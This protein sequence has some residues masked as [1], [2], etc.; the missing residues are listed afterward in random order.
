MKHSFALLILLTALSLSLHA[1]EEPA[2]SIRRVSRKAA[3]NSAEQTLDEVVVTGTQTY[4]WKA[5]AP[6]LTRVISASDIEKTDATDVEELLSQEIPGAEFSYAMNQLKH[7]N[8]NGFGGQ[9]ILF[10]V[11]GERLSG[12]TMDDVDFARLTM[13]NVQRVE[14]VKESGS[15]LYGSNAAGGII[16]IITKEQTEPLR[17]DVDGRVAKHGESRFRGAVGTSNGSVSNTLNVERTARETYS[18]HNGESPAAQVYTTVFGNQKWNLNDK[19]SFTP[20]EKFKITGHAGYYFQEVYRTIDTPERYRDFAASLRATWDITEKDNLVAS[21]IFDQY[22]KS[23]FQRLTGYDIRDYSN[24]KNSFRT[25][26]NHFRD[27]GDIFTAGAEYAYDYLLNT[28]LEGPSKN[29]YSCSSFAQYDWILSFKWEMLSA[30]RFDYFS[31]GK[32]SQITP[33]ISLRYQPQPELNLRMG[34]G[35]GFRAPALKEKYY[36]F[37]MEGIW[38]IKGNPQLKAEL[39]HNFNVSADYKKG[40]YGITA[41]AYY[42]KVQNKISTS[43]PHMLPNEGNQLFLEYI[44]LDSYSVYGSEIMLQGHWENGFGTSLSYAYTH[45]QLPSDKEGNSIS[46][47]YIPAR[48]H[49]LMMRF[50]WEKQ[51]SEK[52]KLRVTLNGRMLSSVKSAEY[53]DY[54]DIS[55]GMRQVEYPAYMLWKLS[56]CESFDDKFKLTLAVDNLLN[57]KPEYH[58]MNTPVT[59]GANVMIGCAFCF[60]KQR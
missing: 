27:D 4:K 14:I 1:E 26:Y 31:E 40:N 52:R 32:N 55:K 19:I 20:N 16:N 10:L 53:I 37:D 44:N 50:D 8:L 48:K 35:R 43:I 28:H 51:T 47:P 60:N 30:L 41:S 23:D 57:Y 7:L 17:I 36:L 21:Y 45:E 22:D 12:E 29:Q 59:D 56:A 42:N 25:L 18:V 33:K 2:D 34:Y 49:A 11:D 13:S 6:V 58:Y 3:T 38:I 46:S 39:S 5:D 24:V 54:Y 9:S 15:A